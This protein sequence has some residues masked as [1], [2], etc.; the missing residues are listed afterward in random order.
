MPDENAML[1]EAYRIQV[2]RWNKRRDIE[3]RLTLTLWSTILIITFTL[4]GK[5]EPTWF[6][7]LIGIIDVI[8]FVIY[9]YWLVKLWGRNAVDKE[10]MYKYQKKINKKLE[11]LDELDTTPN[12]ALKDWSI[13]S[14]LSFTFVILACSFLVLCFLPESK[15]SPLSDAVDKI[16][17]ALNKLSEK[18]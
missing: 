17:D 9:W 10:W 6:K 3:W 5:I 13:Q 12:R 18:L 7:F 14:Q 16:S 11:M 4:A 1:I 2:E 8:L 15:T